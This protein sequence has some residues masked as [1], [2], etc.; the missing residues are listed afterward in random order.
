MTNSCLATEAS[1]GPLTRWSGAAA[2]APARVPESTP[3][4]ASRHRL[5]ISLAFAEPASRRLDLPDFAFDRLEW[6]KTA[7]IDLESALAFE[8]SVP[9][10]PAQGFAARMATARGQRR[11]TPRETRRRYGPLKA[12]TSN[13]E[14][15]VVRFRALARS[16]GPRIP[17]GAP[18]L[19]HGL[20]PLEVVHRTPVRCT[21]T[22]AHPR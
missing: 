21:R 22:S 20:T 7:A 1:L 12:E 18:T 10:R 4:L 2:M 6:G 16:K 5:G 19:V 8:R 11:A 15:A 9:M 3:C 14:S 17:P 13:R